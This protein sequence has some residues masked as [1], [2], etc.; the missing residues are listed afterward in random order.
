L[1]RSETSKEKENPRNERTQLKNE[2]EGRNG[3]YQIYSGRLVL[4]VTSFGIQRGEL[5]G[6][7]LLV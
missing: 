7:Q 3:P 5:F 4:D 2:Q 6:S 1:D